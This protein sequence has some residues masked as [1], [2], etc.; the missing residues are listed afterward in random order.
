MFN[1]RISKKYEQ[2]E[3]PELGAVEGSQDDSYTI[4]VLRAAFFPMSPELMRREKEEHLR[5]KYDLKN[6]A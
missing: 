1:K 3:V 2:T 4:P 6:R 5:K